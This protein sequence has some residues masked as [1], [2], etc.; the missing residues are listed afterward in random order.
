MRPFSLA[1]AAVGFV[2]VFEVS[3]LSQ[4]T[5]ADDDEGAV[6]VGRTRTPQFLLN[7]WP[8]ARGGSKLVLAFEAVG[9]SHIRRKGGIRN[10]PSIT[11]ELS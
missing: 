4:V 6:W 3:S 11:I 2:D 5:D 10:A 8:V 9:V 1:A 7:K